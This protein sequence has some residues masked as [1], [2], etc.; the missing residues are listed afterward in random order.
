MEECNITLTREAMK[1]VFFQRTKLLS[2]Q[3]SLISWLYGKLGL[4]SP[5]LKKHVESEVDL[6][7]G[8]KEREFNKIINQKAGLIV[9]HMSSISP[10]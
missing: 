8:L 3:N 6:D 5:R 9:Q 1:Y 2:K 10:G 4:R 7:F